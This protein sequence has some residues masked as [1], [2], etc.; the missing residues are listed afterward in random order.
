MQTKY[1]TDKQ[2]E[3]PEGTRGVDR[4]WRTDPPMDRKG[5]L[6]GENQATWR[7]IGGGISTRKKR[8]EESARGRNGGI[9]WLRRFLSN[10]RILSKSK[11]EE[12]N[13]QTDPGP[14]SMPE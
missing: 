13:R 3:K 14:H 8:R 4:R 10:L 6:V 7:R 1:M 9:D 11:T 12:E 5:L 2:K